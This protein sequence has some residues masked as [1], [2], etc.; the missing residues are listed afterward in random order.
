MCVESLAPILDRVDLRCLIVDDSPEF[1][2]AARLLLEQEGVEVVD[3]AASAEEAVRRALAL[4]P[5]VTLV[6]IYLDGESGFALARALAANGDAA[7]GQLIMISTHDQDEFAEL[8]E[9][10]PAIGFLAKPDLSAEA[11]R[12]LLGR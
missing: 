1:S 7:A 5:D 3:I 8:I 4:R 12:A 9:V 2:R 10:S 11:I 6:D